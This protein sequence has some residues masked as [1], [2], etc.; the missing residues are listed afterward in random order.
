MALAR[1]LGEPGRRR[2]RATKRSSPRPPSSRSAP[3]P[4]SSVSSPAPPRRVSAPAVPSRLSAAVPPETSSLSRLARVVVAMP[5]VRPAAVRRR[6]SGLPAWSRMPRSW[7]V[8][9][10]SSASQAVEARVSSPASP[11]SRLAP[12]PPSSQSSPPPPERVSAPAPPSSRSAPPPPASRSAAPPP[13]TAR[14]S[15]PSR[16]VA[17]VPSVRL[18]ASRVSA[19]VAKPRSRMPRSWPAPPSSTASQAVEARVSSPRPP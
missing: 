15:R 11:S 8:P 10:S 3:P 12:A 13:V 9:P 18:P 17:A 7:P 16:A 1:G 4:P 5:S 6:A 14:R 19:A 2:G